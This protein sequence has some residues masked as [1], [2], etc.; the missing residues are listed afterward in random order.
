MQIRFFIL[1]LTA[2]ALTVAM[3]CKQSTDLA[4]TP[5][6]VYK[7]G[8]AIT[9]PW[10]DTTGIVIDETFPR[11]LTIT[12]DSLD[13]SRCPPGAFCIW[14]GMVI[15]GL[16]INEETPMTLGLAP[17]YNPLGNEISSTGTYG[18]YM[19]NLQS[20]DFGNTVDHYGKEEHY[21]ITVIVD[22]I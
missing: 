2:S 20:V 19:I 22:Q 7:L 12:F 10:D 15:V 4:P 16:T 8:E 14:E 6:Q 9:I 3:S 13:E 17:Q 18:K 1:L 21:S 11:A 5:L